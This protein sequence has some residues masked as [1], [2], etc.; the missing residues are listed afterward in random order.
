MPDGGAAGTSGRWPTPPARIAV[1]YAAMFFVTG[2]STPYL[3][4]WLESRGLSVAEIGALSS[5]PLLVRSLCAPAVGF[6]ADRR[7]AHRRLVIWLSLLGLLAWLLLSLPTA[8]GFTFALIALMMAAFANTMM[9]LVES[10]AMAGVRVHG[11]DYGRMRLWG[12]ASFVA[13]NLIGGWI[14]SRFGSGAVIWLMTAG[15]AATLGAATLLPQP[16]A[17]YASSSRLKPPSFADARALLQVPLMLTLLLAA[18]AVQGAHGMF[19]AYGTLHWQ[20][21]GFNANWFGALWAVGLI[22]EIALFWRSTEAV[23]RVGAA[24][25]LMGGAVLSVFRWVLMGFDPPLGLLVPLQ[26]LHG[27]TFGATHLGAMHVLTKIAPPDRSATAQALL[28]LMTILGVVIATALSARLY[29]LAGGATYFAMAGLA[30]IG[31]CAADV[32]RR[33]VS[34]AQ[35]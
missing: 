31:V 19:Y 15:A 21:Q 35:L 34:H 9:P 16:V 28:S 7:H 11:H 24:G 22:T 18:G 29:P 20:A 26:I 12:S 10:I 5:L 14:A 13:A 27:L 2:A 4:V 8:P 25:L 1:F 32:I 33:R 30:A 6:E 3:P 23:R 17:E